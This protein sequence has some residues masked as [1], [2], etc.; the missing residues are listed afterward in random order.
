MSILSLPQ[1]SEELEMF[2]F[3]LIARGLPPH[4]AEEVSNHCLLELLLGGESAYGE[5]EDA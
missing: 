1:L 2:E 5:G 4:Q 3:E